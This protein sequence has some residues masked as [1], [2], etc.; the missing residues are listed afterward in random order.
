MGCRHVDDLFSF[1]MNYDFLCNTPIIVDVFR[2]RNTNQKIGIFY[3]GF[4][5]V[6]CDEVNPISEKCRRPIVKKL[7]NAEAIRYSIDLKT[8]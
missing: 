5:P 4:C 2:I 6:F 1:H 7:K 8:E 3:H